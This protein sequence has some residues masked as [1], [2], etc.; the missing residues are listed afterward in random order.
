M[1]GNRHRVSCGNTMLLWIAGW[2]VSNTIIE[3]PQLSIRHCPQAA[4]AAKRR[5]QRCYCRAPAI[6]QCLLPM[7]HSAANPAHTTAILL[8]ND[9][10][11]KQTAHAQ[12]LYR[13]W[14]A[15]QATINAWTQNNCFK[16]RYTT[17]KTLD[18]RLLLDQLLGRKH[19]M[20]YKICIRKH[21]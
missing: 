1:W 17:Y 20:Q 2:Y 7:G 8:S 21:Q 11:D 5:M 19:L 15:Y 6:D 4:F 18:A 13:A 10:R 14:S 12:P 9:G 16:A 3:L